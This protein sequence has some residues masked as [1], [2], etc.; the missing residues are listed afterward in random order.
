[1]DT[2]AK[3]TFL[4]VA[5]THFVPC[6][7]AGAILLLAARGLPLPPGFLPGGI[8]GELI[9]GVF[10]GLAVAGLVTAFH[11]RNNRLRERG[12][13][14]TRPLVSA[15]HIRRAGLTGFLAGS[16][17]VLLT[18]GIWPIM[19]LA[20]IIWAILVW[21]LR[22][23]I[24]HIGGMLRPGSVITW[25][26]VGELLRIYLTMLLGFTLLNAALDGLHI[27]AGAHH[28][29]GF[30]GSGDGFIN[31]LYFTVVTMTTVGF[32]DIV[33][34][35]WDAK[36]LLVVQSLLSYFMFALMVGIITRGV[37]GATGPDKAE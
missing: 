13:A 5:A 19:A 15:A 24:R 34:L 12:G 20:A 36:A 27:L 32:G 21:N 8:A 7:F 9:R 4:G 37:T 28:A 35:T 30:H 2:P 11:R 16:S 23:F 10:N 14:G 25:C 26:D 29:F 17:G 18:A 1:M 3:S 6:I 31:A 33:P 22:S